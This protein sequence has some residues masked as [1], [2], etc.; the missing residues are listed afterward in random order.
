MGLL[1]KAGQLAK[2]ENVQGL[3]HKAE[4][5]AKDPELRAKVAGV[6]TSVKDKTVAGA[7]VVK[8]RAE[9]EIQKRR[10]ADGGTGSGSQRDGGE[11][12]GSGPEGS[13]PS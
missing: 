4:E 11:V 9:A 5:K 3:L 8:D 2:K 7:E 10:G 12:G 13:L 6:A 1:Q